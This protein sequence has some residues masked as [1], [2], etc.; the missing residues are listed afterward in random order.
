MRLFENQDTVGVAYSETLLLIRHGVDMP[1]LSQD[2]NQPLTEETKP[3]IRTLGTQVIRLCGKFGTTQVRMCYSNR[4]RAIQTATIIAQELFAAGIAV[5]MSETDKLREVYQGKFIIKDHVDG[6]EYKP[7][8]DA[9]RAWQQELDKCELLYRFGNPL[10]DSNGVSRYPE[11]M[12]WF[13]E[14]GENQGEFS[15]RLYLL[16]EEVFTQTHPGLDV[17]VG[18]QAT[19]SRIQRILSS[20]S[21][22]TTSG[23]FS[24]GDFIRFLEKKGTR[25]PL[26]PATGVVVRKPTGNTLVTILRKE[27]DYLKGIV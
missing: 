8:M 7:L 24:A 13:N 17:I 9:W 6:N 5:Q 25:K 21:T 2:L 27:I 1:V 4:L 16:L 19:C 18:H 3:D 10:P 26:D 22:L 12:S 15:L 11:L 20:A 23:V 14:F